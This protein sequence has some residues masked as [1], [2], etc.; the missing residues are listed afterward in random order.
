MDMSSES[1]CRCFRGA[2]SNFLVAHPLRMV[3]E[4]VITIASFPRREGRQ[5]TLRRAAVVLDVRC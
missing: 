3:A 4:S 2:K 1:Q 5:L